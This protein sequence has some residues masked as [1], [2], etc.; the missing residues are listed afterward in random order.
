M[1]I[2]TFNSPAAPSTVGNYSQAVAVSGGSRTLYLSGQIPV[3]VDGTVPSDFGSQARLAWA[4]I[5]HQL[6]AAGMT[7]DNVVKHT[8]YLSSRAYRDEL[9]AVRLEVLGALKPALT[10]V[11]VEIFDPAWLL[12]VEAIAID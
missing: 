12:E 9:R 5:V 4:N 8:T 1:D 6:E 3:G 2:E 10:V 7:L 11:I